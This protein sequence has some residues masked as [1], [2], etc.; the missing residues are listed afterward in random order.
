[1]VISE[2]LS[3]TEMCA[4]PAPLNG[5]VARLDSAALI[6]LGEIRS[7]HDL[8]YQPRLVVEEGVLASILASL[9]SALTVLSELLLRLPPEF[10][11]SEP[12]TIA[13]ANLTRLAD[14]ICSDCLPDDYT[15][16]LIFWMDRIQATARKIK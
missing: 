16:R 11:R 5:I 2:L 10:M 6:F 14:E 4:A 12:L 15:P 9:A 1:M 8:L 3:I 13:L 7:I